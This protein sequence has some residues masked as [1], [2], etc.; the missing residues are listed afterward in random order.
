MKPKTLTEEEDSGWE[1]TVS[2]IKK[3]IATSMREQRANFTNK[4]KKVETEVKQTQT[5]VKILEE[6]SNEIQGLSQK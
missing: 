3:V 2:T 4:I 1:G 5:S 6:R